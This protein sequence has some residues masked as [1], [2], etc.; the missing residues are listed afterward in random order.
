MQFSKKFLGFSLL[1]V[2]AMGAI[3]ANLLNREKAA[4][5]GESN[6]GAE[7]TQEKVS[8]SLS[9]LN[10]RFGGKETPILV[11]AE[12]VTRGDLIQKVTA[13]GRVFAYQNIE[14]VNEI[15]G[16]LVVLS[17]KDGDYV[18]AGQ[19]IA[20]VDTREY[21]LAV[22]EARA[23]LLKGRAEYV[24]ERIGMD[25]PEQATADQKGER[26]EL[27]RKLAA[28]VAD[29]E[30]GK[31]TESDYR[32]ERLVLELA[33]VRLG[34]SRE[35][36]VQARTMAAARVAFERAQLNLERCEVRAPFSGRI[37]EVSVAQGQYLGAATKIARLVN[38][39]DLVV[40]AQVLESE[41]GHVFEDRPTKV[42]FA[43]LPDLG[44]I[45]GVVEAISPLVNAEEKTVETIIRFKNVDNRVRPGM[46]AEVLIDSKIFQD[47]LMVPKTA[48]L[49]RNKRKVV[50]RVGT[51]SRAQ[52][53]YVETG[54]ENEES[55]EI[56]QGELSENDLVLTD[57]HFTMGH[58][59]LVKVT[60]T[61]K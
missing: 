38:M 21:V 49:P 50:F 10:K 23:N 45:D 26:V 29:F 6:A 15:A 57:N 47:R 9:S 53:L 48:I 19:V 36:V 40:K 51:D 2:L 25:D 31:I 20:R 42:S 41:I 54:V 14:I 44:D 8:K 56:L 12:P 22:E 5:D 27:E 55:I 39:E 13:Q 59:T 3:G 30:A 60:K 34:S 52:W 18:E 58:D 61:K 17:V 7:E 33:Q 4:D 16:P 24:V 46:F 28:L 32:H 43:A 37:F 11:Q 35:E 1:F